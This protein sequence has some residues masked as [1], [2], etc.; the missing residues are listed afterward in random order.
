MDGP[1]DRHKTPASA[2]LPLTDGLPGRPGKTDV[3]ELSCRDSGP[4]AAERGIRPT[5]Q[6]ALLRPAR[7]PARPGWMSLWETDVLKFVGSLF[8][9][10]RLRG[11]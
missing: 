6:Q 10:N 8:G 9:L 1:S 7:Q 4:L 5:E 2:V 11:R 3:S